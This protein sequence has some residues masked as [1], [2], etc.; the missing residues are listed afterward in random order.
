MRY[1][2]LEQGIEPTFFDYLWKTLPTSFAIKGDFRRLVWPIPPRVGE[3]LFRRFA[4]ITANPFFGRYDLLH[5]PDY[6]MI[7]ARAKKTLATLH[8]AGPLEKPELFEP[9]E[10]DFALKWLKQMERRADLVIAVSEHL[11]QTVITRYRFPSD[12]ICAIPL[13]IEPEFC[14]PS[15]KAPGPELN[16]LYVGRIRQAK[17][18]KAVCQVFL[19][20]RKELPALRLTLVGKMDVPRSTLENWLDN[21][22]EAVRLTSVLEF[23]PAHSPR[24]VEV[25]QSADVFLF[26]S[27]AEGWTSPP[28]EAMA[29]GVPVVTSNTSS[30][31]ETVGQAALVESPDDYD[32]LA[33]AVYRLLTDSAFKALQVNK[34]LEHSSIFSWQRM[35]E[36]TVEQYRRLASG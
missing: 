19:R 17:N 13:G 3:Y 24:L 21:D 30:L 35:V 4:W 23:I 29:C 33:A 2:P 34:G 32:A 10:F 8:T 20:L 26:P 1:L 25:Y 36:R 28:L 6:T 31:P 18:V 7:N 11:R 9:W 14:L 27:Y 12:R 16:L 5:L 15:V 22:A